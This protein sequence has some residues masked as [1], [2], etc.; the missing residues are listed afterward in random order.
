MRIQVDSEIGRLRRV[1]VHRPGQEIDRMTPSMMEEL[2]FDDILD[3]IE[4][5]GL[6]FIVDAEYRLPDRVL[7]RLASLPSARLAVTLVEGIRAAADA[8]RP[9]RGH[10]QLFDLPP[11]PNFFFQRDPQVVLGR[12]VVVSSMATGARERERLLARIVFEHHPALAGA[13]EGLYEIDA[14]LEEGSQWARHVPYGTLEGGDVL[15]AGPEVVLVGLSERT[16]RRGVEE[17]AEHLR[18][19]RSTFRH[20][21]AP[22]AWATRRWSSPATPSRPTCTTSTSP[23]RSWPSRCSRRCS[24]R[25]PPWESSWSWC[26]AAVPGRRSTSSASSGPTAPTPS[27][28]PRG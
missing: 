14:P 18:R 24:G 21:T 8:E 19:Q 27:R 12:R 15:V 7:K 3:G 1:L 25:W 9:R 13:S 26:R 16:N 17:L 11:L 5:M 22:S 4:A 20:L 28:S 10:R 6:G 23:R 2:L